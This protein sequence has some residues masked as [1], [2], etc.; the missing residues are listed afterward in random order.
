MT[1][2]GI[3]ERIPGFVT[4]ILQS[5]HLKPR[6]NMMVVVASR[7]TSESSR[8]CEPSSLV[9]LG[10]FRVCHDDL[11]CHEKSPAGSICPREVAVNLP[12]IVE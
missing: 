5:K 10:H 3:T 1:S 12:S 11:L 2:R 8:K 6:Y 4:K 9:G 7:R